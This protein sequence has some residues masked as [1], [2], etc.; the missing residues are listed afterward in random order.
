MQA[1]AG[2]H[3]CTKCGIHVAT[4]PIDAA[5]VQI[6][7]PCNP[8]PRSLLGD[9]WCPAPISLRKQV[10]HPSHQ[11][12]FRESISVYCCQVCGCCAHDRLYLLAGECRRRLEGKG[13]ENLR[14]LE[15]GLMLGTSAWATEFNRGRQATRAPKGAAIFKDRRR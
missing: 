5:I 15:Q 9:T 8:A 1:V 4:A 13:A 10:T 14:R 7:S 11:L 12:L 2:G 3:R 6:A